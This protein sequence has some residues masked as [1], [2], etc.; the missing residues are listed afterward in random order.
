MGNMPVEGGM[1]PTRSRGEEKGGGGRDGVISASNGNGQVK[2]AAK[3]RVSM[4]GDDSKWRAR[5][6][7]SLSCD[8]KEFQQ[9]GVEA[10][11]KQAGDH[12]AIVIVTFAALAA[13][14]YFTM[15]AT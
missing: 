5:M 6:S 7:R 12:W 3:G 1:R 8:R 4:D 14:T 2:D 13:V 11:G 9:M 15:P 10:A